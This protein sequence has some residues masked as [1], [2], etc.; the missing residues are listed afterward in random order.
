M[1]DPHRSLSS[2][3]CEYERVRLTCFFKGKLVLLVL[4][5]CLGFGCLFVCLFGGF[6]LFLVCFVLR[7]GIC[8]PLWAEY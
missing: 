8:G 6:G 2:L 4:G 3:D 1:E 5:F 7:G